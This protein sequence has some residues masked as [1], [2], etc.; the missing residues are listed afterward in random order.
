V[1]S[2]PCPC[3]SQ[4]LHQTKHVH[5]YLQLQPAHPAISLQTAVS[6]CLYA[7]VCR[8]VLSVH[9]GASRP[10]SIARGAAAGAAAAGAAAAAGSSDVVR[11]GEPPID[12]KLLKRFIHYARTHCFPRLEEAAS[13]R[14]VAKFVELRDKVRFGH[15]SQTDAAHSWLW[16]FQPSRSISE[17]LRGGADVQQQQ[18]DTLIGHHGA[19]G[20]NRPASLD[21]AAASVCE[22]CCCL[23]ARQARAAADSSEE[24][25]IPMTVR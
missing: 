20:Q 21:N 8:H 1:S 6:S 23:Q 15:V 11:E 17:H 12:E 4:V 25:P 24:C 7:G 3:Q 18:H 2:A 5:S 9:S 13:G 14:L 19:R 16:C 22:C 10:Q